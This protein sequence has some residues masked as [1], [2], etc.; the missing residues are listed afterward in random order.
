MKIMISPAKKM[1]VDT[2]SMPIVKLPIY[3]EETQI[4]MAYLQGLTF[5]E[6]KQL[7]GCNDKIAELN[8]QRFRQMDLKNGLTPAVLSY[9][10]LQYQSMAP[11]VFEEKHWS[12]INQNLRILSGFYGIL[13]PSDGVVP[14]RL[15]MQAKV[16]L[17]GKVTCSNLYEFWGERLYR[18]LVKEDDVILNLASREYSRAVE[19]YLEEHIQYITCVFGNLATDKNGNKKIKVKATEAKMA[20]GEM[21]RFLAEHGVENPEEIRKFAGQGFHYDRELSD[22]ANYIF[23]KE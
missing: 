16:R 7:W 19:P 9:E 20:R 12:Y 8:Y 4:L 15:E 6:A 17:E 21:V 1:N 23:M 22:P 18:E 10:G 3:L 2:D 5:R 11:K 13:G 14:Y